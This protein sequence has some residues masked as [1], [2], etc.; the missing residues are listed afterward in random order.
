MPDGYGWSPP[1]TC[2]PSSCAA[3]LL[4]Q[5]GE[6]GEMT[7]ALE[8]GDRVVLYTDGLVERPGEMLDVG[9]ARLMA[10]TST[11]N[12]LE[13]LSSSIRHALIEATVLRD[14]VALLM[15]QVG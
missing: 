6:Y 11:T 14:D 10:S 9:L 2:R 1:A 4:E 15:A 12:E 5:G 7:V 8:A 3:V 13:D